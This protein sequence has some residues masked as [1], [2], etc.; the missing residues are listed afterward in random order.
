MRPVKVPSASLAFHKIHHQQNTQYIDYGKQQ[1][2][3]DHSNDLMYD[4]GGI[5]KYR[6]EQKKYGYHPVAC[7]ID[8]DPIVRVYHNI[9]ANQ[10]IGS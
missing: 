6:S 5:G 10:L 9:Y 8:D 2:T 1:I 4:T 7:L 3:Y